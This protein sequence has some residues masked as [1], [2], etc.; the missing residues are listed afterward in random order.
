MVR[1]DL[2]GTAD[3]YRRWTVEG[4]AADLKEAICRVSDS[5]FNAEENAN[6]PTVTYEVCAIALLDAPAHEAGSLPGQDVCCELT[7]HNVHAMQLPDGTEIQVGPDRFKVPEVLFQP[8]WAFSSHTCMCK[9]LHRCWRAL[10]SSSSLLPR[11]CCRH[12]LASR[13]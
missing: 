3:S 8:V 4:V 10:K 5:A 13:R 1:L 7:S 2:P 6:I 11:A 9:D 12:S